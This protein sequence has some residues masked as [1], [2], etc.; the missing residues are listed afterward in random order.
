MTE[1]YMQEVHGVVF[2]VPAGD[3]LNVRSMP[4]AASDVMAQI[5][6]GAVI[7]VLGEEMNEQTKWLMVTVGDK[8]GWVNS[9]YVKI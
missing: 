4:N 8:T 9:K 2:S 7:T 5:D 1:R 6:D 3:H